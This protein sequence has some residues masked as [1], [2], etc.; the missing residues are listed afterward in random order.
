MFKVTRQTKDDPRVDRG[1]LAE[2]FTQ[3]FDE[4]GLGAYSVVDAQGA[5]AVFTAYTA[6]AQPRTIAF[7]SPADA[8]HLAFLKRDPR[9]A[10]ALWRTPSEHG[11][12]L[13]G[14]QLFGH[15]AEPASDIRDACIAAYGARFPA[16]VANGLIARLSQGEEAS[17]TLMCLQIDR[18]KLL[19][20][21]SFGR[22]NFVSVTFD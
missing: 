5:P 8:E 15:V 2:A 16:T 14:V 10:C 18:A 12:G 7:F 3:L 6:F 17:G 13:C 21:P 22:R 9:F 1:A 11:E 4:V 20:E 19:F